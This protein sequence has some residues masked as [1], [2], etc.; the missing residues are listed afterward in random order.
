MEPVMN[1]AGGMVKNLGCL[2]RTVAL[3]NIAEYFQAME[4]VNVSG[5]PKLILKGC[6]IRF[7]IWNNDPFHGSTS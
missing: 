5:S 4:V 3:E 7:S 2:I 6:E 1:G